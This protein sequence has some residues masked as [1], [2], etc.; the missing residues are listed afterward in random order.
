MGITYIPYLDFTDDDKTDDLV[1]QAAAASLRIIAGEGVVF[2]ES[3]V[4]RHFNGSWLECSS[5]LQTI[6]NEGVCLKVTEAKA[7][8]HALLA[9]SQNA[10]KA[11]QEERSLIDLAGRT[12]FEET[13]LANPGPQLTC[14]PAIEQ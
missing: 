1:R 12:M 3:L 11:G 6:V 4:R 8:A 13:S 2:C 10:E 9:I 5:K 7:L 14:L